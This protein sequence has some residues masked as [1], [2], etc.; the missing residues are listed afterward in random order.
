MSTPR[1]APLVRVAGLVEQEDFQVV[2]LRFRNHTMEAKAETD[3]RAETVQFVCL[4]LISSFLVY[5]T[6]TEY[7]FLS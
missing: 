2:V 7:Y 6:G 4:K 1:R 3:S 5:D